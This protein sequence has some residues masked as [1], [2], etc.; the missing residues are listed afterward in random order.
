MPFELLGKRGFE[1]LDSALHGGDDADQSDGRLA[2]GTLDGG[3]L[4]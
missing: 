4:A 1:L 2:E 3:R